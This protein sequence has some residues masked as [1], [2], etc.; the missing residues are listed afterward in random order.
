MNFRLNHLVNSRPGLAAT[1]SRRAG[2][3]EQGQM[4]GRAPARRRTSGKVRFGWAWHRAMRGAMPKAARDD[5]A[6]PVDLRAR[7]PALPS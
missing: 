7:E 6:P 5:P 3:K 1:E 2:A 4:P